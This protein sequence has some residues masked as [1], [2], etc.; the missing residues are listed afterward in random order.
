[1]DIMGGGKS[2]RSAFGV[3]AI[4]SGSVVKVLRFGKNQ[5]KYKKL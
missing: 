4:T 1:M 5:Y 2:Q 3:S